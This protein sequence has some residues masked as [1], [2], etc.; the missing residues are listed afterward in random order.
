MEQVANFLIDVLC[1]LVVQGAYMHII[2][3]TIFHPVEPDDVALGNIIKD[4]VIALSILLIF[5]ILSFPLI[6]IYK[7][8]NVAWKWL[9]FF[10]YVIEHTY[11][12]K[13]DKVICR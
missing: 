6:L 4:L 8:K 10:V 5:P 11:Q 1:Q 3:I 13:L 7:Q 12:Y 9:H 2:K